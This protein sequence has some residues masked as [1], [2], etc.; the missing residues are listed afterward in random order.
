MIETATKCNMMSVASHV[1]MS[2][3]FVVSVSNTNVERKKIRKY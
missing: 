1:G 3:Y 2:T